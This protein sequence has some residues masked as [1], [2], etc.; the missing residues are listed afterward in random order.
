MYSGKIDIEN[1]FADH[2]ETFITP[3]KCNNC[4]RE[5]GNKRYCDWTCFL[6]YY[7]L[8]GFYL[9]CVP[10]IPKII[11]ITTIVLLQL[12]GNMMMFFADDIEL[13][14][15]GIIMTAIGGLI[16][17]TYTLFHWLRV[18]RIQDNSSRNT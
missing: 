14:K 11:V 9:C 1:P 3:K 7:F 4:L 17:I 16:F 18:R 2:T 8:N 13:R 12:I 6:E 10:V 5:T 15:V